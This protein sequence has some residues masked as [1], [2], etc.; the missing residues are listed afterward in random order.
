[1]YSIVQLFVRHGGL[2]TLVI[3]QVISF[4]L[5]TSQNTPQRE[6]ARLS[7][8][9]YS[10][11]LLEWRNRWLDYLSLRDEN[12][13]LKMENAQLRTQ[14]ANLRASETPMRDTVRRQEA[15]DSLG[16]KLI[17]PEYVVISAR[18]VGNTFSGRHNWLIL[19]R[20]AKDGIRPNSGVISRSGVVGIVRDVSDHFSLAMSVLHPQTKISAMVKGYAFYGS[21]YWDEKDPR[22]LTLSDI[23]YHLPIRRGDTVQVSNYSLIFP[24]GHTAGI[25]DTAY[26]PQGSSF[27]HIRV[28]PTQSPASVREVYVVTNRYAEELDNL[29]RATQEKR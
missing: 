21:L 13:R 8:G 2:I 23:P 18:V 14:L 20:G 15:P 25:V 6:I 12:I 7:W 1:M 4:Y 5:M 17:R 9:W 3:A 27:L 19:N 16:K 24:E 26:R 22:Y 29:T 10:N 28:R 11:W